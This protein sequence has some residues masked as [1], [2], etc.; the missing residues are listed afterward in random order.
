VKTKDYRVDGKS[1][2]LADWNP[3]DDGGMQRE[4]AEAATALCMD[5]MGALQDRLYAAADQS[6]LIVLQGRDA[7]GKDGVIRKVMDAFHPLGVTVHAFRA[8]NPEEAAHDFLWR[9]HARTPR[10]GQIVVF[11]R[12]HYEDFL[13]PFVYQTVDP[14]MLERRIGHIGHFEAM[15]A[16]HRTRIVKLYLHISR[17]EQRQRLQ[18]RLDDVHKQ[19]KFDPNDLV[20]RNH[21]DRY[22][23]AYERVLPP[24][25][26]RYAPWYIV[27]AD[28]K[29][30]RNCLIARILLDTLEDMDPKYPSAREDLSGYNPVV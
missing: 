9:V 30:F 2:R 14:D 5:K 17:E 13:H 29:W 12:S 20:D 22:T 26:T 21:W 11:N 28:R 10:R 23:T 4:A 18:D 7:S 15:L 16:D 3:N 19:W 25:A 8:P 1:I 6:L 24:T 27:P